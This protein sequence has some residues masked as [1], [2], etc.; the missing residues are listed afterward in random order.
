[1]VTDPSVKYKLTSFDGGEF[2]LIFFSFFSD[3]RNTATQTDQDY[4]VQIITQTAVTAVRELQSRQAPTTRPS[5]RDRALLASLDQV[6]QQLARQTHI[7]R[8]ISA[9][10]RR[11]APHD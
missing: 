5:P 6:S 10:L 8:Q 11:D 2:F 1:M 9:Q 4:L 7:L 3:T